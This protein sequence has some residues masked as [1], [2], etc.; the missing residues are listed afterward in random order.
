MDTA[1]QTSMRL[2][3][4]RMARLMLLRSGVDDTQAQVYIQQP[5]VDSKVK[6]SL[7]SAKFQHNYWT[8]QIPNTAIKQGYHALSSRHVPVG[9]FTEPL[10]SLPVPW[11]TFGSLQFAILGKACKPERIA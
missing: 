11:R 9:V 7:R 1:L 5:I 10:P 4:L 3:N 8:A 6:R 2:A